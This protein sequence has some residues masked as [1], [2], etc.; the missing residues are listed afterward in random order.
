M[1]ICG[2][3]FILKKFV[4]SLPTAA[5]AL[6]ARKRWIFLQV[7]PP[8]IVEY[9]DI[10]LAILRSLRPGDDY[11]MKTY[12]ETTLSTITTEHPWLFQDDFGSV[13]KF[14]AVL[15]EAQAASTMHQGIFP[16]ITDPSTL[17]HSFLHE[18]HSYLMNSDLFQ[19]IILAGTGLSVGTVDEAIRSAYAKDLPGIAVS[20]VFTDTGSFMDAEIHKKYILRYLTM[21]LVNNYSDR[22]LLE[23]MLYWLRGRSVFL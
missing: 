11:E 4:E 15:D 16:S 3:I 2:R 20:K 6:E 10:F 18:A 13:S 8:K 14:W 7:V 5:T 19:G 9:N 21:D 17:K 23:R 1:L 12:A 22:R